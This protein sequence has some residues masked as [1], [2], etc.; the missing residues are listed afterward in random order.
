MFY[1]D[2]ERVRLAIPL[3]DAVAFAM[4]SSDLGYGETHDAR[5]QIVGLLA[6][7][8]LEYSEQWRAAALLRSCLEHRWAELRG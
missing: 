6:V 1:V 4:G 8:A 3:H 5:R 2:E 7:D